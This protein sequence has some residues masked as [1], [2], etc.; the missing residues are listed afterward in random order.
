[1]IRG[2]NVRR[3]PRRARDGRPVRV[4]E[5]LREI[6]EDAG[7]TQDEVAARLMW[8]AGKLG[9]MERGTQPVT[10]QEACEWAAALGYRFEW[11]LAGVSRETHIS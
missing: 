10:L 8:S 2:V 11:T 5:L 3:S 4:V 9:Y 7:L 1:M 6:R